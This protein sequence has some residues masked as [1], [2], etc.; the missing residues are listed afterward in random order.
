MWKLKIKTFLLPPLT[1]LLVAKM[2]GPNDNGVSTLTGQ[3]L[4]LNITAVFYRVLRGRFLLT[5]K[6]YQIFQTVLFSDSCFLHLGAAGLWSSYNFFRVHYRLVH[7]LFMEGEDRSVYM[8]NT[9]ILLGLQSHLWEAQLPE[10]K[11]CLWLKPLLC[12]QKSNWWTPKT[13]S[14]ID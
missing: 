10:Q 14:N 4:A 2:C 11:T 13:C 9:Q 12:T 3:I 7:L 1:L 5:V 6:A 8:L